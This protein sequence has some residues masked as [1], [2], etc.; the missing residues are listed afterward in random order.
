MFGCYLDVL[1]F[2]C[3]WVLAVGLLCV[4]V[5]FSGFV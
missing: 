5:A 2:D 3:G 1:G 4:V